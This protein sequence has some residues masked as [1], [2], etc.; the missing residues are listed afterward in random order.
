VSRH[1]ISKSAYVAND[2]PVHHKSAS[3]LTRSVLLS[4]TT[5]MPDNVKALKTVTRNAHGDKVLHSCHHHNDKSKQTC[6]WL[7]FTQK[8][9]GS[10]F[11]SPSLIGLLH[12]QSANITQNTL[13]TI[14][15]LH[16]HYSDGT[17]GNTETNDVCYIRTM[18]LVGCN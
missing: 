2:V 3:C 13:H 10:S 17:K 14:P 6:C 16:F 18:C 9:D 5:Y 1:I 15:M 11:I 12:N 4:I 7:G 8:A